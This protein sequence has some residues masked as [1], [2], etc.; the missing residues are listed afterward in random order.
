MARV[1]NPA[2]QAV[3]AAAQRFVDAALRSDD[4]L[5]T[6]GRPIWTTANIDELYRRLVEQPD[7]G[8]GSFEEKL[9]QQ[10]AGAPPEV[11]QFTGELIYLHLLVIR[12]TM[13]PH[14]KRRLITTV[15]GWSPTP[16][17]AYAGIPPELD[18]ALDGGL[19]RVG[20]LFVIQRYFQLAFLLEFA[21]AWKQLPATE[22]ERLLADPWAFK[23]M[24]SNF[25]IKF[26][27]PQREALLHLVHPDTFE[28]IVSSEYK[29]NYARIWAHYLPTPEQDVDRALL[30]I[31]RAY[32]Q[33]H[34]KMPNFWDITP[35]TSEL[36]THTPLPRSLGAR[37]RTYIALAARLDGSAYTPEQIL[38]RFDT[39][40]QAHEVR[41]APE[42][43]ALVSDLLQL[44]LVEP[45]G[46][47]SYR[48][49]PHLADAN[50]PLML[51]YAALTLL[52]EDGGGY[53]LP[54]LRAPLD[55]ASH[56]AQA[57]PLGSDLLD[58]YVE[59]GL[60]EPAGEGL[61]RARPDAL[62]P[63]NAPG[64]TAQAI[65]T[66]LEHLRRVRDNQAA[67]AATDERFPILDPTVLDARIAEIQRELLIDRATILRIYRAL[68]AGHHV[69]L[70][71]PPGTGKTH[72]A[73]L[74]PRVLWRDDDPIVTLAM[75]A[76]PALPPTA[77]PIEQ[78]SYREGYAVDLVTATEDWGVRDVLGGITPQLVRDG[79]RRTLVYRVRRGS[80]TRAVLG[81][82]GIGDDDPIQ[83]A[84]RLVRQEPEIDGTR[85]RG[86]WL[87]ID[88]FTRA[89]IDA[90]F[91]SLLTTLGGQRSP[92]IVPTDDGDVAVPLPRDFRL[93]G[94]LNSFDR[95]F[96]NQISEAMKRRFTF[97]D[98]LPPG[99]ELAEQELAMA[100]YR[101]LLRLAEQGL[102][103]I[104]SD[105]K[106]AEATW[107]GVLRVAPDQAGSLALTFEEG[108]QPEP[109]RALASFWRI[110]RAVRV[111]RLLGTAQAEAVCS[112]LFS[113]QLIGMSWDAALDS[114][115][116]D[117]LADQLQVLSRDEQR[118]LL[119][120]LRHAGDAAAFSEQVRGVLAN[121]PTARQRTHLSLLGIESL[122]QLDS[123]TLGE[124]FHLGE[125][126]L[127]PGDG[128]FA[129][130]IEAF[131]H[132]R[133]L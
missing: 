7:E 26:A 55:G 97:I 22:R 23:E 9:R 29:R 71:G 5:F 47:G 54:L 20:M 3:Y 69:I 12:E 113:G 66:F 108:D 123:S 67:P 81:N 100:V 73:R 68:I 19:A 74:L 127:M 57:W 1:N 86:R 103:D 130:R 58:W 42:P 49:W 50:E 59:A 53:T 37:L 8:S 84:D 40:S 15:L 45:L 89:P 13:G 31:R 133:G 85:Y 129:R 62:E 114:A 75:P 38:E 91:G 132:E 17:P 112:A 6:P 125:Q 78:H 46:D 124:R 95:H 76:D 18:A 32:E 2:A 77:P 27:A 82:Y 121:T 105:P 104:I 25:Q 107:E 111:Y 90:A 16:I 28:P 120:Y 51:R 126:L 63:V 70:S 115:L 122:G 72:L 99:P 34:G 33:R 35:E 65:N 52:V 101:A 48:R 61:W 79:D 116:A 64:S 60:A 96:L 106:S 94:T 24:L 118:V 14:A 87:V 98:V 11:Y 39:S 110:F 83:P 41:H 102:S 109:A 44:R 80:L 117:T 92:L 43:A 36:M 131:I 93:I 4:S 21:R 56:P 88:E 10:L 119:A 30:A 128:L